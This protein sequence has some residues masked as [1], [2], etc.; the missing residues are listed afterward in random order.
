MIT[1]P[2]SAL[3]IV[4]FLVGHVSVLLAA[5]KL[6]VGDP[7][8]PLRTGKW[9]QGEPVTSF[10]KGKTYIVEFWATWCPPCRALIPHLNEIYLHH[11]DR[12]LVVIGQDI[13]EDDETLVAP[14]VKKMGTNMTYRVA[15]DDKQG[16]QRP[17]D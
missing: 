4:L 3:W 17:N 1:I 6:Q 16:K 5:P 15:L 11:K 12:G 14:F 7:A 13:R 9:I 2:K 8:P 10:E